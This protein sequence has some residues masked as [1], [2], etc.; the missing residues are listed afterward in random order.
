MN[1]I[2]YLKAKRVLYKE[3]NSLPKFGTGIK[4][5]HNVATQRVAIFLQSITNQRKS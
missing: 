5:L 2:Y 1:Y 4:S 3:R